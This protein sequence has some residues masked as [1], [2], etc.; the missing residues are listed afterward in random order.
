MKS[1]N[2]HNASSRCGPSVSKVPTMHVMCQQP[3][4]L[5]MCR[6]TSPICTVGMLP[7]A[8]LNGT[9]HRR[10]RNL[11]AAPYVT[12]LNACCAQTRMG[13][14]SV[15]MG[16]QESASTWSGVSNARHSKVEALRLVFVE[17]RLRVGNAGIKPTTWSKRPL[18]RL[19]Y[20]A[21]KDLA[22]AGPGSCP[23]GGCMSRSVTRSSDLHSRYS[24]AADQVSKHPV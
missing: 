2:V 17:A 16:V 8:S 9:A 4:L 12:V 18:T 3:L 14:N 15:D 1:T 10:P 6:T 23:P 5:K 7:G 24:S 22:C 21:S 20:S 11:A 13:P 19:S